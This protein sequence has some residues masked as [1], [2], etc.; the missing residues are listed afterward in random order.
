MH[1]VDSGSLIDEHRHEGPDLLALIDELTI[2]LKATLDI[3]PRDGIEDLPVR[4]RLTAD[5]AALEAFGRALRARL[6]DSDRDA[7][8]EERALSLARTP[9]ERAAAHAGLRGYY[10]FRGEMASAVDA[11]KARVAELSTYVAPLI[12][13]QSQG[14][15]ILTYIRADRADEAVALVEDLKAQLQPPHA[16]YHHPHLEFHLAVE[17]MDLPA[18]RDA[19]RRMLQALAAWE[20]AD[21]VFQPARE[22]RGKLA[23]LGGQELAP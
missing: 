7:A 1:G 2:D 15:D 14:R 6:V 23:E 18:A 22:A 4:E 3:P 17:L 9:R 5:D 11:M 10:E 13:A 12:L 8:L 21:E 16:T 19:H 20:N